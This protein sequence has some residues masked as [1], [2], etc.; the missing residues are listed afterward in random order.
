MTG[1]QIKKRQDEIYYTVYKGGVRIGKWN[2]FTAKQRKELAELSCREM[3]NSIL[4]YNGVLL[5]SQQ[6]GYSY[7]QYLKP[8]E[9]EI[10]KERMIELINEQ[11]KDF[12]K[13]EV[14][15]AGTDSEGCSYNYCK[16][17]D[18]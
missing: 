7:E 12:E 14:G 2:K 1:K 11:I 3:I 16:W 18:D 5:I 6:R 4:I 13:A 8:R 9:E 17:A 15:Y 10:G